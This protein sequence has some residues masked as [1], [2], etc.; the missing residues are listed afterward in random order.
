MSE[1]GYICPSCRHGG[2][3]RICPRDGYPAELTMIELRDLTERESDTDCDGPVAALAPF[4]WHCA[5][6]EGQPHPVEERLA[7]SRGLHD[8]HGDVAEWCTDWADSYEQHETADPE[9]PTGG[10]CRALRG[11]NWD[12]EPAFLRS[13]DRECCDR[14]GQLDCYPHAGIRPVRSLPDLEWP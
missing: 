12:Q 5:N 14:D 2:P 10:P 4:A 7:N 13:G 1:A 8:R 6:G 11:G 3:E 9:G